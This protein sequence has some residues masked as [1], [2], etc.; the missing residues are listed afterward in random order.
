M[1]SPPAVIGESESDPL[2]PPTIVPPRAPLGLLRFA[3]AFVRNPLTVLPE[4]VYE[5][6]VYRYGKM[7]TW[8]TDPPLIKKI[9]LDEYE[10]FPKTPVERRVLAPLLGNGMLVSG[11]PE[12]KWQRQ[13]TAPVFRQV[14]VLRY[15]PAM[16]TAA[17]DTI[18]E[19][20]KAP[21]GTVQPIDANMSDASYAVISDT[22]LAGADGQAFDRADLGNVRYSWPFAYAL[23]GL[24]TWLWYPNR[25]RKERSEK[26]MREAVLRLVQSRRANPGP[27]DDVLVHLLR[28]KDPESGQPMSDTQLV[29]VLLTLLVAGHETT[30]KALAWTLYLI[31]RSPE[32]EARML[33]EV[34]SVAGDGPILAEHVD[35]LKVTT[36]VLKESMR[37][38]SPV[39]TLT[40]I[41][42]TDMDL[43]ELKVTAG[44]MIFIPIY[45]I[46][47]HKRLWD[48]PARFDPERFAPGRD[49]VYSRYQYFPFGAGPRICVGASFAMVE[50]IAMLAAFVRAA[51]FEV[52]EGFRPLPVSRVTLWSDSGMPLKVWPR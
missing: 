5:Q 45:A 30:A 42:K 3:V 15:T 32:W 4:A 48:D 25:G 28:A 23:L 47:R 21:P 40:R 8:V 44:S 39:P 36:M 33:E 2:Y 35:K 9:L 43:G 13:T 26:R 51:R 16:N 7:L 38:Y 14:E 19:W 11:G 17:E 24:P 31:A 49:S 46:H 20:R 10:N 52:P 1:A 37:L 6:P 12:W 50:S 27:R 41:A 29:D 22:M 34:R 18:A